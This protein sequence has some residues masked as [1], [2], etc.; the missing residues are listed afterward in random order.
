MKYLVVLLLITV[1]VFFYPRPQAADKADNPSRKEKGAYLALAAIT[2]SLGI[3][4]MLEIFP[5]LAGWMDDVMEVMFR[6]TGGK[7]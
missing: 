3:M 4:N 2:L 6:M 5:V 1:L 7:I